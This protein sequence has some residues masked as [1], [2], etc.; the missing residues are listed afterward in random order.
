MSGF[1]YVK[2]LRDG[3]LPPSPIAHTMGWKIEQVSPGDVTL[4]LAPGPHL[5]GNDSLHG[6]AIAALADSALATALNSDLDMGV[7]CKT[8]D[9]R[10]CFL[11]PVLADTGEIVAHAR[12]IER[13]RSL[14]LV[15]AS[16]KD[17]N[18]NLYAHVTATFVV[19]LMRNSAETDA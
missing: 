14:A 7:R 18:G 10:L 3:L 19:R 8:V 13:R 15:E 9:L 6:G 12:V 4:S 1:E 17:R 16:I 11:A 5:F 2:A